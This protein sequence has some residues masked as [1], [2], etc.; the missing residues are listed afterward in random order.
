[1]N[2]TYGKQAFLYPTMRCNLKCAICYSGAHKPIVQER[3]KEELTLKDYITVVDKLYSMGV[4][5]FDI[6]GGEPFLCD[7]IF[8]LIRYIK[9]YKDAKIYLVSNGTL[10]EAKLEKIAEVVALIDR[11]QVSID[12]EDKEIHDKMRGVK[13]TFNKAVKGIQL[14]QSLNYD[15]IGINSVVTSSNESTVVNLLDFAK[16]MNL[17]RVQLLRFIDVAEKQQNVNHNVNK[18]DYVEIYSIVSQWVEKNR[19]LE[20]QNKLQ[21]ELVLPGYLW[22]ESLK[23]PKRRGESSDSVSLYVQYDPFH[24]C[25]AFKNSIVVTAYGDITG[26]TGLV[27]VKEFHCGNIKEAS[28]QQI[29]EEFSKKV[30]FIK[31]REQYLKSKEP[32]L[33]CK[34]YNSCKG[35]CLAATYNYYGETGYADPTC[36]QNN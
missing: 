28:V 18:N 32:C 4:R 35:G 3:L 26:C 20:F 15:R 17:G 22:R 12:S 1:M 30:Q 33:K 21:I 14:L 23:V 29:E 27:N 16:E 13:G 34:E 36:I 19:N 24:G 7:F 8:D 2:N 6:S 9:S 31:E 25:P 5:I 10:I 11:F